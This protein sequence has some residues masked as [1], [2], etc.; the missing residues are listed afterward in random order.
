MKLLLQETKFDLL[1][2][3]ETHLNKDIHED[4]EIS[5]DQ[6]S[7]IRKDRTGQTNH[8]GG[9]LVYYRNSLELHEMNIETKIESIW[10]DII[11]KSQKLLLG[12]I[13]RPPNDKKFLQNF[14][15]ILN[16]ICHRSNILLIGDF[17]IDLSDNDKT[18]T[19]DFKQLLAGQNL[20]NH[21]KDYT[22]IT[23]SSKTLIDLA[24]TASQSKV[25]KSGT[26]GTGISDH[27]LIYVVVN[28]F[29]KKASPKLIPV[30]NYKGVDIVKI[31]DDLDSVPWH[32]IS[33]F[34]DVDDSLWC[35]QHLFKNVISDHVV[36]RKVKVRS[37]NQPWMTGEV[38]KMINNRD[39]LL[40][41]A[42]STPRQSK[43]WS[44]YRR[45]RNYCTNY[46]RY[47]K[48]NYWKNKFASSDSPKS[49]W[50]LV[51]KFK[52]DTNS[53]RIGPLKHEDA[54]VTNDLDK[55]NVMNTFFAEIG[56]KLSS[57]ITTDPHIPNCHIYRVTPTLHKINLSNKLLTHSFKS[58]VRLGKACGADNIT[59]KDLKL[60]E[61]CTVTGLLEVVKCSLATGRFPTEW[62]K[63]KV[64]AVYKKGCKSE[65][66][67]YRP[68]SLLSVPSKK[69]EHFI[70]SQLNAHLRVN[71]LLN[72]HQW[73]FR[74]QRS[75]EDVL[76]YMTER[77]RKAIDAGKVVGVLFIDFRK[78]FDSVSHQILLKKM[79]ACGISGEFHSY[80]ESY[81]SKRKQF[82]V[83]NGVAS[84]QADVE[85]G[86]PQ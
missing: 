56:K 54:T 7:L 63:S 49:F 70:C 48:A 8:W 36:T 11:F 80:L 39:K 52:G 81:L 10:L 24:I 37:N 13:Y 78:A 35:W 82:T 40:L 55:A 23:D 84:N 18:L 59:P 45:A 74:P 9:V 26:F 41:K 60:H 32:I 2:I 4:N 19:R 47:T 83:L 15:V 72:E 12:C 29:R 77:W 28:S 86:V 31:K 62:K 5:I 64:S 44:D 25:T 42:R 68:I 22:R 65:C 79:S 33:V 14:N 30:R 20:V 51:K 38:R 57:D 75:T 50:S 76:L 61:E 85:F 6:Y 66:S 16:D 71:N 73:G 53:R 21:I 34:D 58:A 1:A 3:T 67:N 27:D 43:E 17:N 46:I 69:V